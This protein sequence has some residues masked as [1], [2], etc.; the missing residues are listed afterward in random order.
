MSRQEKSRLWRDEESHLSIRCNHEQRRRLAIGGDTRYYIDRPSL[1][2][3]VAM[4]AS[5]RYAQGPSLA[6]RVAM[7][8]SLRYAQ[9]P[10]LALFEVAQFLPFFIRHAYIPW[11]IRGR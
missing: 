8:A 2:L 6:L 7:A 5:L 10:S 3:R 1:A 11:V 9:R 4:A